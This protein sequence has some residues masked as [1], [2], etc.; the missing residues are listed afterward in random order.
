MGVSVHVPQV[1]SSNQAN[2]LL[3]TTPVLNAV[4]QL[5]SAQNVVVC[6]FTTTIAIPLVQQAQPGTL[7]PSFVKAV[8]KQVVKSVIILT[9]INASSAHLISTSLTIPV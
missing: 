8:P 4:G 3:A 1:P 2:A 6:I 9:K 7:T 5:I